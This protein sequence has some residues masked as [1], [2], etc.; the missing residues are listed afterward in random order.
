M[1]VVTDDQYWK[2]KTTLHLYWDLQFTKNLNIHYVL[3]V[4]QTIEWRNC[5]NE[6]LTAAFTGREKNKQNSSHLKLE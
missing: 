1:S 5:S 3:L 6:I 2:Y 4:T